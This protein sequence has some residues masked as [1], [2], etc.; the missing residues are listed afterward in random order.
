MFKG[1]KSIA[2]IVAT[3]IFGLASDWTHRFQAA[4]P[5]QEKAV[6]KAMLNDFGQIAPD[7]HTWSGFMK[8]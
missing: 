4:V 2:W 5:P 7:Q 8:F 1:K 6:S 3:L